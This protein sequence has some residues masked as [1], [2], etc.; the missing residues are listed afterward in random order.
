MKVN[1]ICSGGMSTS[2]IVDK[3]NK[4]VKV[5]HLDIT[6]CA[7]GFRDFIEGDYSTDLILL[8]PQIS[9]RE[10]ELKQRGYPVKLISGYDYA[11]GNIESILK[12]I[13]EE[14]QNV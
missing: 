7:I 3:I 1:L 4:F 8:A 13:Q 2:I 5:N 9:F 14:D 6:L 10:K 11:F 12:L